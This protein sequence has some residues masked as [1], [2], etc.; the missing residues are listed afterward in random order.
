MS[1]PGGWFLGPDGRWYP[2]RGA[3]PYGPP[4]YGSPPQGPPGYGQPGYGAPPPPGPPR[5]RGPSTG[6]VVGIVV[7]VVVLGLAVAG[8]LALGGLVGG[9]AERAD[10]LADGFG[11]S[12]E[13]V[14]TETV[15]SVLGGE[16][17]VLQLDGIGGIAAPA[18]DSR[19][20]ADAPT[21]W[22]VATAPADGGIGALTRI[23]RYAGPDAARRFADERTLAMGIT[24]DRG[25]GITVSSQPYFNRDV[26]AGDQAFCTT[27]DFASAAGVLVRRGEVLVYVSTTAAGEGAL[28]IPEIDLAS[29][30]PGGAITYATDDA[31]C[32]LAVRLAAAVS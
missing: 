18:L 22:A 9:V 30:D 14:P 21:C 13:F 8:A 2:P 3:P 7:A 27:G 32:D 15:D 11:T 26:E 20:L 19:V 24:E 1:A 4:G 10:G 12:C 6:A 23:A 16:H 5:R 31:N 29:P 17:D 25:G 28:P